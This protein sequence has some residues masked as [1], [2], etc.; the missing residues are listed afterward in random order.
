MASAVTRTK[1]TAAARAA[2]ACTQST[3][4]V[5]VAAFITNADD[6]TYGAR[7]PSGKPVTGVLAEVIGG[8]DTL[9]VGIARIVYTR[10]AAVAIAASSTTAASPTEDTV[11]ARIASP[12]VATRRTDQDCSN[13]MAV[14]AH[15]R[16]TDEAGV[17]AAV[18]LDGIWLTGLPIAISARTTLCCGAS[19][20][21][22]ATTMPTCLQ[23]AD[24]WS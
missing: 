11:A 9:T 14:S 7:G 12:S 8:S 3:A 13:T 16:S 22:I 21:R 10:I 2:S 15:T 18:S 17:L 6:A 19:R 20:G 5:A 23:D 24:A 4:E 1:A